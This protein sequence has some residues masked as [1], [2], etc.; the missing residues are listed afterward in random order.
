MNKFILNT[1]D[2]IKAIL[3]DDEDHEYLKQFCWHISKRGYAY[4]S[5][6]IDLYIYM[7]I[8]IL[9]RMG[10][11]MKG[12]LGDHVNKNTIDNRRTNLRPCTKSQ[13]A[14]NH[15][16]RATNKTGYHGVHFVESMNKYVAYISTNKIRKHLGCFET[17][18]EAAI[19]RDKAAKYYH[20]EFAVLNFPD[21]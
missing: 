2:G 16:L 19:E 14:M 3:V 9:E 17:A 20:K 1:R 10:Y 4:Y 13:N 5:N 6:G 8:E 21:E 7:H 11:D 18:I 12:K 15:E